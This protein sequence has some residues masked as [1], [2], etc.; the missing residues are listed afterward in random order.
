M[1]SGELESRSLVQAAEG[2]EV[3][4]LVNGYIVRAHDLEL[5]ERLLELIFGDPLVVSFLLKDFLKLSFCIFSLSK[6]RLLKRS[7][8]SNPAPA[9]EKH[10]EIPTSITY[11]LHPVEQV[12]ASWLELSYLYPSHIGVEVLLGFF[13]ENHLAVFVE[14]AKGVTWN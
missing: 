9:R 1:R 11:Q 4:L 12:V 8:F 7:I 10:A 13:I 2:G 14:L 3:V 5:P 6:R